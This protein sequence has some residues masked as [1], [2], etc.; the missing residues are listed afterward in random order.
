MVI[1]LVHRHKFIIERFSLLGEFVIGGSTVYWF[2]P[3]T[4]RFFFINAA[5]K[6]AIICFFSNAFLFV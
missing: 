4:P 6:D 2:D 5:T 1:Q 3:H